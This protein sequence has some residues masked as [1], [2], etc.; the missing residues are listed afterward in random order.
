MG[1][2]ITKKDFYTE[3]QRRALARRV[4]DLYK[5]ANEL[6]MGP[7]DFTCRYE[8]DGL[9]VWVG[10]RSYRATEMLGRIHQLAFKDFQ[11]PAET[12]IRYD[13]ERHWTL[14]RIG[15]ELARP[16]FA[17]R[18]PRPEWYGSVRG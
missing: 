3:Q 13:G 11:S 1:Y 7:E 9:A 5:N 8:E 17:L 6:G 10:V 12:G 16:T 18:S 2:L 14:F 4:D 15:F